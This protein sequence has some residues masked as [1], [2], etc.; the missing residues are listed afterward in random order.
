MQS[1]LQLRFLTSLLMSLL[2]LVS[3]LRIASKHNTRLPITIYHWFMR[4]CSVFYAVLFFAIF[5]NLLALL[6]TAIK[7]QLSGRALHH[8]YHRLNCSIKFLN[9]NLSYLNERNSKTHD[10]SFHA[11]VFLRLHSH[12]Y[13]HTL[14]AK[15][16]MLFNFSPHLLYCSLPTYVHGQ[17]CM[18]ALYSALRT[19]L[20]ERASA[21]ALSGAGEEPAKPTSLFLVTHCG[22]VL[23][24]QS[25]SSAPPEEVS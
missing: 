17:S 9:A 20:R 4:H 19:A 13:K 14:S 23:R 8:V 3:V 10:K 5:N 11:C 6:A 16:A 22:T 12:F 25:I 21:H 2:P 1:F 15:I 18:L 24:T 7:A